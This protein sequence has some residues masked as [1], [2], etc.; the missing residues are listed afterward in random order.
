MA[1]TKDFIPGPNA[2]FDNW[3][4]SFVSTVNLYISGWGLS[5]DALDEWAT[6]TSE[7][8]NKQKRWK[9]IWDIVKTK[10]FTHSQAQECADARKSY[11]SGRRDDPNDTSLRLYITRYIRNNPKVS[12]TQKKALKITVPDDVITE[13]SPELAKKSE[14]ALEGRIVSASHL[15]HHSKVNIL[16]Q[17]DTAMGEDVL[18]IQ[19]FIAFTE[20]TV[21]T[22]PNMKDFHFDG[23]VTRGKY[24]RVFD[25]SLVGSK[26]WYYARNVIKGKT[27]TFGPPSEFWNGM[28]M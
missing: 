28:V 23:L 10:E 26:A 20:A 14:A 11:E 9:T 1:S 2:D 12:N 7:P 21:T 16:G 17:T 15:M 3:Q 25:P 24:D 8:S 4:S 22:A 27:K 5:T 19:V 6:L 13:T 18:E